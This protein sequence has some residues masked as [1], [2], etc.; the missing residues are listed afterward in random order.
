MNNKKKIILVIIPIILVA[1]ILSIVLTRTNIRKILGSVNL[2][3]LQ[4]QDVPYT[5]NSQAT[6]QGAIDDLYTK[7]STSID[8]SISCSNDWGF[9]I[10][11]QVNKI[12]RVNILSPSF[13]YDQYPPMIY[14]NNIADM[15][16]QNSYDMTYPIN[17][18]R[19]Y[20]NKPPSNMYGMFMD[21]SD[22]ESIAF[23]GLNKNSNSYNNMFIGTTSLQSVEI[24][25]CWQNGG[26]INAL[27]NQT[28]VKPTYS[29]D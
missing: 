15:P 11:L 26:I 19:L 24:C 16:I 5:N 3:N 10:I 23:V 17:I 20:W 12:G 14:I 13:S 28:N 21:C 18:V 8:P 6:V 25:N 2:M 7:A 22:I 9:S 1:V 27:L 4:A 29:C